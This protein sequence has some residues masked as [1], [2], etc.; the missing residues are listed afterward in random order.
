MFDIPKE[1]GDPV[2]TPFD[3]V[4][5]GAGA[6]GAPLAC[7]L[8]ERGYRVAVLE[9]GPDKPPTPSD[10][11]V[12]NTAVPLLHAEVTEDPRHALK[13]FVRHLADDA[14]GRTDPKW[15]TSPSPDDEG[16]FYPRAQGLGGCTVHNA[17]ITVAG[18]SEDWDGIAEATGDESWR[19][20]RM[21]A[22]FQ[23]VEKCHYNRPSPLGRLAS[24]F[25]LGTGWEDDRHGTGGW[26]DTTVADLKPL[27]ADKRLLKA[28]LNAVFGAFRA[29]IVGLTQFLRTAFTGRSMPA[30]DP[31]HWQTMRTGGEGLVRIPLAIT[32]TGERSGPRER[33]NEVRKAVGDRLTLLSGVFVTELAFRGDPPDIEV[34]GVKVLPR[35][36]VYQA[37]PN[38]KEV[39]KGWEAGVR[40]V[41]AKAEV[42]LCGGAFNTPQLLMLSG[43]GP[44][45]HLK[46]FDI[47]V[48]ANRP[49]VGGN[50]QDRYEV[51]VVATV[52]DGFRS[53]TGLSTTSRGP[54]AANDQH[55]QRWKATAGR[56]AAERGP[57]AT[58]GGLLGLFKRSTQ[59][60]QVPDLFIFA[61]AGY[62]PGYHVGYSKP[63]AFANTL[64]I[65]DAAKTLP[66]KQQEA[67]DTAAAAEPK[68]TITWLILK[69]RTRHFGGTV[70]LQ[71]DSPFRRP[72]V[73]FRSFPGGATD[74]DVLALLD[75]V[76]CVTDFLT[77]GEAVKWIDS[78]SLP[79]A[80]APPFNGDK[81]RWVRAVAWGHHASGTCRIGGDVDLAAVL[82]SRFRVRGVRRLRVVDASCFPRIPGVFIVTNVY[83]IAEK[84]ADVLTEDHPPENPTEAAR[85]ALA[86]NPVLR[87]APEYEERRVYP[88][89]L[90]AAEAEMIRKR[91]E[92]SGIA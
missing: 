79:G 58:N 83:M 87:S 23:R 2:T 40:T 18:P 75:G 38:A 80:D 47:P 74:P 81:N 19:G 5:V 59:E 57:Y 41:C 62:F 55:L 82:D 84:A 67:Q 77:R 39:K 49:G 45:D 22:Y 64:S 4:I 24:W 68:K 50:L 60:D 26:L 32:P 42:I 66:Q 43:I 91:R 33:F 28:V 71:S 72:A 27:L 53:V 20:E 76:K 3:F 63:A 16:V 11:Q 36:H 54:A 12:E 29:G 8:A 17:M 56:S 10:A 65:A 31:N 46:Q 61:L 1:W 70:R 48:R 85:K 21:R 25:G 15:H 44:G 78:H 73:H 37:D 86:A 14:E 9:M 52:K 51:P 89:E 69:A 90:E 88:T 6:G 13:F 34:I 92:Q 30:L 7:R 35:E